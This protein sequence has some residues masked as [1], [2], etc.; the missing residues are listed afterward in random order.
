MKTQKNKEFATL[1]GRRLREAY[2]T[3]ST[4]VLSETIERHLSILRE[5]EARAPSSTSSAPAADA[6]ARPQ[7][8]AADRS[9][10]R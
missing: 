5:V 1:I 6:E 3:S 4:G 10:D 2:V 9:I 8:A 7:S